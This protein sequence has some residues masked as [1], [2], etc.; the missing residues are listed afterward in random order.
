MPTIDNLDIKISAEMTKASST[1]DELNGKLNTLAASLKGINNGGL[2]GL[3]N[4]VNRLSTAMQSMKS[5]GTAEF[6]KLAKNIEKLSSIPIGNIQIIGNSLK[7]MANGVNILSTA[8]FDS[9]NLQNLINILT[10][11]AN[12]NVSGLASV[13][14]SKIGD[15]IK[16]L[17]DTLS[18]AEKVQQNTISMVN[19]IAQ[20]A[21]A[22][23][24]ANIAAAALPNLELKLKD[25]FLTM[26]GASKLESDTITFTQALAQLANAGKKTEL[27]ADGL[28]K[29]ETALRNLIQTLSTAPKVSQNTVR[30]VEALARLASQ[31][32]GAGGA[33]R[34]IN[35]QMSGMSGGM[36]SLT[37]KIRKL[38]VGL[39][40]LARQLLGSMGIYVGIYGAVRGMKNAIKSSMDYIE[41][42]NYFDA[43]FGQ[44]AEKA[45]YSSFSEMGYSSAEKYYQSFRQRAEELTAK[46]TGYTVGENGMLNATGA[47]SLG[48]DPTQLMNYQ[49]MFGQ[50]SSSI[51]V[52]SETALKL[53]QA[54][55]EIGADLASV[56][57]MDFNKVWEDMAS[58]LAG[59]SRTLDKYGVNIR[60]VNLQQ[61]LT[62]LG[63]DA[64]ISALNQND[65]ALL[66]AI[67]LLDSTRYAW[68]DLAD[69]IN[70]PANQLRLIQANFQNLS[71]TIGSLFLPLVQKVLPYIN[72]L[73]IALQRLFSWLGNLLGIDLSGINT[74]I[75]SADIS[76]IL[77]QTEELGTG[78]GNAKKEADKLNKSIR[79]FDELKTINTKE[80]SD[81]GAGA[82]GGIGGGMLDA[83]FNDIFEEYQKVWDE[84]FGNLEN[85]AQ[86]I[87]DSIEK[88]FKP[89]KKIIEDFA[90]GD[91]FQAGKDV[92]KLVKSI[93]DFFTRAIKKV[94]WRKIGQNIG[95]FFAGIDW[96]GILKSIGKLIW[97]ALNAALDLWSGMFNAAPLETAIISLIAIPKLIK[98]ITASKFVTW[99]TNLASGIKLATGALLGNITSLTMLTEKFPKLGKAVN[100]AMQAFSEFKSGLNTKGLFAGLKE[101]I[102]TIRNS[103]SGLQ[104]GVIT[105]VAGFAEFSVVNSTFKGLVDGSENVV[106]G[107]FKI[108]AAVGLA[109]AAMYTALG[110][111]GL[112]IA[113]IIG[114][115]GAIKG[116]NDAF[117][118]IRAEEIGIIIKNAMSNPGGTPIDE[119]AS[120]FSNTIGE[121]GNSFDIITEKSSGL[122]TADKNIK[123]IWLEIEKIEI[124]MDSGVLSVEEGTAELTRLFGEL[125]Q[126]A[127]DKFGQ[128]EDTLIAAFGENGVLND[129]YTRLGISTENTM[130][131]I[132]QL[133]D[134]VEKRINE[135]TELLSQTDPSNPNYI[136][137]KEELA[138][139]MSQTSTLTTAMNDYN[140]ALSQ[141]DYSKL[142]GENGEINTDELNRIMSEISE[143]TEDAED[144]VGLAISSLQ[145]D[146]QAELNAAL[147]IN[148]MESAEEIRTKMDALPDALSLLKGDIELKAVE[149]T[150]TI[151]NDFIKKTEDVIQD[152]QKEWNEKSD[153]DKFWSGVFGA[154]TESE[155]VKKAV[156]Q[157]RK[158]VDE[159]SDVIE[160]SFGNLQI[161]G[162]VW[163]S[164]AA[165]E[166]YNALFDSQYIHSEMGAG[167][168]KYTLNES[169][170]DIIN[171]A[172]EGIAD[173]ASERG[174][175][176]VDGYALPFG[177]T[178]ATKGV[179][180]KFIDDSLGVIPETQN[181]H[182]PS[183]V[184]EG[185]GKD[186][187]DGYNLGIEK[188]G[189]STKT[190]VQSWTSGIMTILSEWLSSTQSKFS[191]SWNSINIKNKE[192]WNTI[193]NTIKNN[194]S[195]IV[196]NV[197]TTTK[198]VNL[199]IQSAWNK[200]KSTTNSSWNNVKMY[201]SN[202][203]NG[204][205]INTSNTLN[206][207]GLSISSS[208]DSIKT[209]TFSTW[210]TMQNQ[211]AE[212]WGNIKN[213]IVNR[214][215]EAQNAVKNAI[216][217][218][219][220]AF[221]FSWSLPELKLPHISVSGNFSLKPPSVPSFGIDWYAKGGLFPKAN[222]IGVGEAGA[223]AVIPLTNK[224][225]MGMIADSIV[226]NID[227]GIGNNGGY[228]LDEEKVYRIAYNAVSAAISNSKL[229]ENIDSH[230]QESHT[231]EMDG[232]QVSEIVKKHADNYTMHQGKSYFAF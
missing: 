198:N 193:K 178:E 209:S 129:V 125:A 64:N 127:S 111:A 58:G 189:D 155:Y 66:R 14:F 217:K 137:Y 25:F 133:N 46:M 194:G 210:N 10:R 17:S 223:E 27:T 4:G 150:D 226:S 91:F 184:T 192:I 168:Y 231:I 164:D 149:L 85:K 7:S 224:K 115:V 157:Q 228:I 72:A 16:K 174:K 12:F 207:I 171:G 53:S 55:T 61:N 188:N 199:S 202:S 180:R 45:D 219:K 214:I 134:K 143:A 19:A 106:V 90:V 65:K 170:R 86:K 94:N 175:D 40:S 60:N 230:I 104:K 39:K 9:K 98:A 190:T 74:S 24:D 84:S 212:T 13:D 105:V 37:G 36:S 77:D 54:L 123:D 145:N 48:L 173:L 76:D 33:L 118:E 131:T 138:G 87:A 176:A 92:S 165:K 89:I 144:R 22:G 30:L 200:I 38:T 146:L 83:A 75:G 206:N 117:D 215:E 152:A 56:K 57:N 96:I 218:I 35:S 114:I 32:K 142:I 67:I 140:L 122:E 63:I 108:G 186:A 103:L 15:S 112:A 78:L 154:G 102:A 119:I 42:L 205:K 70:Q 130:S 43:A 120:Q 169:Y 21:S 5:V 109:G 3:A 79:A 100:V 141:I 222:I 177:D 113:A 158:N 166:I 31:G 8:N 204:I 162:V 81:G 187:I 136:T 183:K 23:Q 107:L 11:L 159:L 182:S 220:E 51:G 179:I 203:M 34:D 197:S 167:H 82:G 28:P 88:A 69:T 128:L 229:L 73:V 196:L 47:V 147:A 95:K 211:S 172:T 121:I 49:A 135:L 163:A 213:S 2:A 29:L 227:Y 59:M 208:W 160:E 126:T 26:S 139:L 161:E 225:T 99:F 181:S 80:D 6:T 68:A 93:F 151:Q 201:I 124:A 195:G 156:D 20:L 101:G 44:V 191:Q 71:R 221:N 232:R 116:I 97:A 185:Y 62:E 18:G 41:I 1:I 216:E 52:T 153:W 148:D 50:M 110:P 132:I